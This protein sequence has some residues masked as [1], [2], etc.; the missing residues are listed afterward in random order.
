MKLVIDAN[1]LIAA[2]IRK[3]VTSEIISKQKIE[4]FSPSHLWDEF[5]KYQEYIL[6]K[7]RRTDA[8]L[9]ELINT[10]K[11][12]ITITPTNEY[13]KSEKL[14]KLISP[15]ENDVQYISLALH[16]GIPIWSNDRKLKEQNVVRV[17][18]TEEI[19]RIVSE[20]STNV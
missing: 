18:S 4:L 19:L 14:A 6:T 13:A 2:L 10:L 9:Q 5:A 11:D 20:D 1:I 7:T 17:Y 8:E 16:L 15:D 12:R 3:S